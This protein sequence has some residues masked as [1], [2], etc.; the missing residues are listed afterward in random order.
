MCTPRVGVVCVLLWK[1]PPL[2]GHKV[3][4]GPLRCASSNGGKFSDQR[5]RDRK[6]RSC[7]YPRQRR[8][9]TE[10]PFTA[11]AFCPVT[12]EV[13]V[14]KLDADLFIVNNFGMS[15]RFRHGPNTPLPHPTQKYRPPRCQ[16]KRSRNRKSNGRA[17]STL[18]QHP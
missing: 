6:L 9:K 14:L 5:R 3:T 18:A 12:S 13:A 17:A 11:L 15:T 1:T 2:R 4:A 8:N 10:E 16:S 7:S